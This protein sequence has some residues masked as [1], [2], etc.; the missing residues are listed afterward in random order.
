MCPGSHTVIEFI[1]ILACPRP[2]LGSPSVPIFILFII[3]PWSP[4]SPTYTCP[5]PVSFVHH[6]ALILSWSSSCSA[7]SLPCSCPN[8]VLAPCCPVPYLYFTS[9]CSGPLFVLVLILSSL[10]AVLSLA[11]SLSLSCPLHFHCNPSFKSTCISPTFCY[12]VMVMC[13]L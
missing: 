8:P 13:S 3:Q 11:L 10:H 4:S 12:L 6:L 2:V 1:I 5:H 7:W 9:S